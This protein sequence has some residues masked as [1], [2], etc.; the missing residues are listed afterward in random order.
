MNEAMI[1]YGSILVIIG[2]AVSIYAYY[3]EKKQ[4]KEKKEQH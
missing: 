4:K 3:Q 1:T 2:I